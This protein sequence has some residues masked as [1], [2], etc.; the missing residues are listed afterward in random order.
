M[1]LRGRRSTRAPLV[2]ALPRSNPLP[3][4]FLLHLLLHLRLLPLLL[5]LFN[6]SGITDP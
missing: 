6:E 2:P 5:L 4:F 1:R 3:P